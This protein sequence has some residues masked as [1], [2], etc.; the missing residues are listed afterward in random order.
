M[1]IFMVDCEAGLASGGGEDMGIVW[2]R[3]P[4]TGRK[5]PTGIKIEARSLEEFPSELR[6]RRCPLCGMRHDWQDGDAWIKK[7][8]L[9]QSRVNE[10][11]RARSPAV[12][13][14]SAWITVRDDP[15]LRPASI[16]CGSMSSKC[17]M[18]CR[19]DQFECELRLLSRR[20]MHPAR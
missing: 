5:A 14:A 8:E 4:A 16:L 19:A 15:G 6:K 17:P 11:M 20:L 3:C 2:I 7:L 12:F 9:T 10:A 18:Y 1:P 13:A